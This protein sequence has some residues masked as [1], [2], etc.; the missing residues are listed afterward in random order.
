ML[1]SRNSE[2][3]KDTDKK[4]ICSKIPCTIYGKPLTLDHVTYR[5]K[6]RF[7]GTRG[8]LGASRPP[9]RLAPSLA[10][11]GQITLNRDAGH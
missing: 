5:R 1:K 7:M 3:A 6:P 2:G 11:S 10:I 4:K 9:G 8:E